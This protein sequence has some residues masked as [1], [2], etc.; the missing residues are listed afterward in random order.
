MQG[1]AFKAVGLDAAEV[2][3]GKE[4]KK[5]ALWSAKL[6]PVFDSREAS[7]LD[8]LES[9]SRAKLGERAPPSKLERLSMEDIVAKKDLKSLLAT[10]DTLRAQIE[11]K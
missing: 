2:W 8:A 3:P 1:E 11:E 5:V 6:W 9:A 7:V 4:G 10:I